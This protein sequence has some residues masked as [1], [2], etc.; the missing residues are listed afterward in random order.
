[1]SPPNVPGLA[2]AVEPSLDD[3]AELVANGNVHV[4]FCIPEDVGYRFERAEVAGEL[5]PDFRTIAARALDQ[6][7][8]FEAAP[9]VPTERPGAG[10]FHVVAPDADE[11]DL[12]SPA[13]LEQ[14]EQLGNYAVLDTFN[15]HADDATRPALYGFL[16]H[17]G[18]DFAVFARSVRPANV[19]TLSKLTS[20]FD[21]ETLR[22]FEQPLVV[23]DDGVEWIFSSDWFLLLSTPA[24]ESL[25]IDR[26]RLVGAVHDQVDRLRQNVDIVGYEELAARCASDLRMAVKLHSIIHRGAYQGWTPETLRHYC[27]SFHAIEITWQHDAMVYDPGPGRRW[28][29]LKL[30][31]EAWFRGFLSDEEFEATSKE[32]ARP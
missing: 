25:F 7:R 2:A 21:G 6:L 23:F 14:V 12:F 3:L 26:E 15:V 13:L 8:R 11:R 16:F 30:Y 29:I 19:P 4:V 9:Y 17:A 5:A 10:R 22:R 18:P 24:F 20:L 27:D 1:V 28:D 32:A 31:D